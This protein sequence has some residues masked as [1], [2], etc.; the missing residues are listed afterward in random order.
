MEEPDSRKNSYRR[1][2]RGVVVFGG[3]RRRDVNI[4]RLSIVR[5]LVMPVGSNIAI[6]RLPV[7]NA[8]EKVTLR[9]M[10]RIPRS[11]LIQVISSPFG[12]AGH[13]NSREILEQ[14]SQD[15]IN[16][17]FFVYNVHICAPYYLCDTAHSQILLH[18]SA[19]NSYFQPLPTQM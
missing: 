7:I 9:Q 16:H 14:R 4:R 12:A 6:H 8:R 3:Q 19:L 5:L 11:I 10:G 18:S 2:E 1:D 13:G 17:M 15:P